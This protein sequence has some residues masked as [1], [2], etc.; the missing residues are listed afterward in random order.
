MS[1]PPHAGALESRRWATAD[2]SE[3][4]CERDDR[5][6]ADRLACRHSRF[7]QQS[8]CPATRSHLQAT[9]KAARRRT[10]AS[11]DWAPNQ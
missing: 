10:R 3:V 6:L 4:I 9:S 1:T 5:I 8:S 7:E 2:V 11:P